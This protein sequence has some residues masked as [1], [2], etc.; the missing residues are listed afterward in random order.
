MSRRSCDTY[1]QLTTP[2]RPLLRW[3][4]LFSREAPF[5]VRD[6]LLD[7]TAQNII[8]R[9]QLVSV[10]RWTTNRQPAAV[11]KGDG[12]TFM[13]QYLCGKLTLSLP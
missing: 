2:D 13:F 3:V 1:P 8:Q 10:T 11:N 5:G 12:I 7:P 9:N 4:D 6:F